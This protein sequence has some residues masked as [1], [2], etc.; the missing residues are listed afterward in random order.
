MELST[1]VLR[2][3]G[4]QCL[5]GVTGTL[6]LKGQ[7]GLPEP[8][9]RTSPGEGSI[10][11]QNY[12][13]SVVILALASEEREPAEEDLAEI[14][15]REYLVEP[16]Q[17]HQSNPLHYWARKLVMWPELSNVAMDL[18]SIPP[19]SIQS[20]HVFSHLGDIL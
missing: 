7:G 11:H 18:L 5:C 15:V 16:P 20:K 6:G 14:L 12:W 2:A 1:E 9:G 13:S 8:Q 3:L 19:T 17:P 10:H 4:A